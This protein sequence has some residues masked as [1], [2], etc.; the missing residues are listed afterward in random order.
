MEEEENKDKENTPPVLK[1]MGDYLARDKE[2]AAAK[3]KL[4]PQYFSALWA[5]PKLREHFKDYDPDSVTAFL[6]HYAAAA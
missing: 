1:T 5:N 3:L 4:E 6:K 2:R